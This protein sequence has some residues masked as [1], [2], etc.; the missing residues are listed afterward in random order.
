[1][2]YLNSM[3]FARDTTWVDGLTNKS[4][5]TIVYITICGPYLAELYEALD[6]IY[7]DDKRDFELLH[8]KSENKYLGACIAMKPKII[9]TNN[10][11]RNGKETVGVATTREERDEGK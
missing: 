4:D 5:N 10:N 9:P 1:M 8:M 3:P 11:K 7:V 2:V 6:C